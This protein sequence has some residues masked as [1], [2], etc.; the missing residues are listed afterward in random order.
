[1]QSEIPGKRPTEPLPTRT[2]NNSG[3]GDNERSCTQHHLRAER[4][5]VGR[6]LKD[7]SAVPATNHETATHP[8]LQYAYLGG[9]HWPLHIDVQGNAYR[10]VKRSRTIEV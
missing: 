1:M 5:N 7:S 3:R 4:Q 2:P 10:N 8:L 9:V 6:H